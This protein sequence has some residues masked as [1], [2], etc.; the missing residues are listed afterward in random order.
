MKSR[1]VVMLE[2]L[3]VTGISAVLGVALMQL[4]SRNLGDQQ[5]LLERSLAQGLCLDMVDR[6]KKYKSFWPL[7][8]VPAKPPSMKP[9]PPLAEMCLPVEINV[10]KWSLFDQVYLE[11]L[12]TLGISPEPKIVRTPD[13]SHP[14]LFLLEISV[15]W[16]SVRGNTRSV[17]FIR[18]CYSP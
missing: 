5:E 2:I 4:S 9:G 13:P 11:N 12:A 16:K 8:G 3:V 15:S 14:G 18:C 10:T 6:F 17:R 1:G 7:P